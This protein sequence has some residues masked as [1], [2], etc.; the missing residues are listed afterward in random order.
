M[1]LVEAIED[2]GL[3]IAPHPRATHLMDGITR[4]RHDRDHPVVPI[5]RGVEDLVHGLRGFA[6]HGQFVVAIG[7]PDMQHWHSPGVL[8]VRIELHAVFVSRQGL[9]L[10]DQD[11]CPWSWPAQALLEFR[12]DSAAGAQAARPATWAG[13][14]VHLIATHVVRRGPRYIAEP[15]YQQWT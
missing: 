7:H 3:R 2:R 14:S 10:R 6:A 4:Q 8:D 12:A 5:A 13:A 15:R 11:E 1:G 9:A